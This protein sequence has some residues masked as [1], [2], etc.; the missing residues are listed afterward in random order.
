M[1][2]FLQTYAATCDPADEL[3]NQQAMREHVWY[4]SVFKCAARIQAMHNVYGNVKV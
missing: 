2:V 4:T 3:A 1:T